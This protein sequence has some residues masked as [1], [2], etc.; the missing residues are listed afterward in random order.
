MSDKRKTFRVAVCYMRDGNVQRVEHRRVRTVKGLQRL[1]GSNKQVWV[2]KE[3]WSALGGVPGDCWGMLY[4]SG[5]SFETFIKDQSAID[6][7]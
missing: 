3:T 2:S 6:E 7:A 4:D 5:I 1:T